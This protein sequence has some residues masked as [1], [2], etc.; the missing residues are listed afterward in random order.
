MAA[1]E[2]QVWNLMKLLKSWT[3][4]RVVA[5]RMGASDR[6][7]KRHLKVLKEDG[8]VLSA[9]ARMEGVSNYVE[10]YKSTGKLEGSIIT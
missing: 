9:K 7:I 6:S 3:P 4:R 1:T 2:G 8:F 5:E 10:V